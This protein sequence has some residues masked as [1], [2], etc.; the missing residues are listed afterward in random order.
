MY[1]KAIVKS[2][3]LM[4][5]ATKVSGIKLTLKDVCIREHDENRSQK[6]DASVS[7]ATH[8]G[9]NTLL[10]NFLNGCGS[11]S[12][13]WPNCTKSLYRVFG[14]TQDYKFYKNPRP[15]FV[16]FS[17]RSSPGNGVTIFTMT[18]S[19]TSDCIICVITFLSECC[20]S[21]LSCDAHKLAPVFVRHGQHGHNACS[22]ISQ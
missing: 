17:N 10:S 12:K 6:S 1:L 9:R 13:C 16:C 3:Q 14:K 19:R 18:P 5:P 4:S 20:I 15:K 7:K 11:P 2:A 21:W 8:T 22:G